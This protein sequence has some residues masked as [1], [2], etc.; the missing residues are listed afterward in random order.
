MNSVFQYEI[1]IWLL[2]EF[3]LRAIVWWLVSL[4]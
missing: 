4:M 2:V 1:G 3:E